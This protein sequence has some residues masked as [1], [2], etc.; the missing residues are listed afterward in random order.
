MTRYRNYTI[1]DFPHENLDHLLKLKGLN[2]LYAQRELCPKTNRPHWQ[3]IMTFKSPKEFSTMIKQADG[4][5]VEV[6]RALYLKDNMPYVTKLATAILDKDGNHIVIEYGE[7]LTYE[8][9]KRNDL[10][11]VQEALDAGTTPKEIA[12]QFFEQWCRYK[13]SFKEYT[14]LTS[15]SRDFKTSFY[16]FY[17]PTG[18]GKTRLANEISPGAYYK[19]PGK[20]WD[21]YD[22]TS[23]IIIDDF[24]GTIPFSELLR[25]TDRYEHRVECKGGMFNFAP[26]RIFITSNYS[27]EKIYQEHLD[28][29]SGHDMALR[30]RITKEIMFSDIT[31]GLLTQNNQEE[32]F[33]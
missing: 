32:N 21:G 3:G 33:P 12:E 16:Y 9:G 23:D 22:G 8:P 31:Y 25:L 14:L 10:I 27:I 11:A 28:K 7:R 6:M 24:M 19:N 29:Y 15:K 30:R 4:T 2:H 20:W 18:T 17:G 1:T 26:K 13:N 5:H